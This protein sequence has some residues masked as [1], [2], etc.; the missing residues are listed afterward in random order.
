[1]WTAHPG[2]YLLLGLDA[3]LKQVWPNRRMVVPLASTKAT[4]K[5][6]TCA[7]REGDILAD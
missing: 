1:M 5:S 6:A 4:A 2:D 3:R 7:C